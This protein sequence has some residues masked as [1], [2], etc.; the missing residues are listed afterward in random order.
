[1]ASIIS[2]E[3]INKALAVQSPKRNSTREVPLELS[4]GGKFLFL[5]YQIISKKE[6]SDAFQMC[7]G[8]W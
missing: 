1:M 8:R 5:E 3:A 2:F 6:F 4:E 7:A